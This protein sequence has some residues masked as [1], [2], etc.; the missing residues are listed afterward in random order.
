MKHEKIR[1]AKTTCQSSL[2]FLCHYYLEVINFIT[3]PGFVSVTHRSSGSEDTLELLPAP[4]SRRR[5]N[6]VFNW[7][8]EQLLAGSEL[9]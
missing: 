9:C 7:V 8:E 5:Q 4:V 2:R 6:S 1:A 3:H